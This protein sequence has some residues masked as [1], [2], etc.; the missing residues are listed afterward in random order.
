MES[1]RSDESRQTQFPLDTAFGSA[2]EGPSSSSEMKL[3]LSG[4]D[5]PAAQSWGTISSSSS[6]M[7]GE[8]SEGLTSK[9]LP[10]LNSASATSISLRERTVSDESGR[11]YQS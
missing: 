9:G 11:S 1:R 6:A 7:S 3:G 10:L 8:E 5:N 2:D 4:R